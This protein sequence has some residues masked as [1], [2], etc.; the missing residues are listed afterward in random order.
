MAPVSPR[1]KSTYVCPSTSVTRAPR[2][3]SASGKPPAQLA[4]H[5]I[6]TPVNRWVGPGELGPGPG[7]PLEVGG[8]LDLEPCGQ[9]VPCPWGSLRVGGA[10]VPAATHCAQWDPGGR[11]PAG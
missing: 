2:P 10:G 8:A 1:A 5:V 4:I 6:G 11:R 7:V 3:A 9:S